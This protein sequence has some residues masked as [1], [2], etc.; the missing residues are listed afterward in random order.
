MVKLKVYFFFTRSKLPKESYFIVLKFSPLIKLN[1]YS[2]FPLATVIT[3]CFKVRLPSAHLRYCTAFLRKYYN[4]AC[5]VP[6][7]FGKEDVCN[8]DDVSLG[9]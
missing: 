6:V 7:P 9:N 4:F 8:L 5:T 1:K 3:Y 2:T